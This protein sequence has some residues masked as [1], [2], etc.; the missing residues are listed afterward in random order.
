MVRL[1]GDV[2]LQKKLTDNALN[3]I[4]KSYDPESMLRIRADFYETLKQKQ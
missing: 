2:D 4:K 1:P 3:K